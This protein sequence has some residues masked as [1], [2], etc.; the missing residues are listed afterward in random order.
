MRSIQEL[1][2]EVAY[3]RRNCEFVIDALKDIEKVADGITELTSIQE[4]GIESATRE[5]VASIQHLL[6][7]AA[8]HAEAWKNHVENIAG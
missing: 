4:S 7:A 6:D 1:L 8:R 3:A 5:E 2:A